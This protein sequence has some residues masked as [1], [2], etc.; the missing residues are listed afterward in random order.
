M[1]PIPNSR[2]RLL[3]TSRHVDAAHR[4]SLKIR[5]RDAFARSRSIS[6]SFVRCAAQSCVAVYRRAIGA[7]IASIDR[8]IA[9]AKYLAHRSRARVDPVVRRITIRDDTPATSMR[10]RQKRDL[11]VRG[12]DADDRCR[13]VARG[14]DWWMDVRGTGRGSSWAHPCGAWVWGAI[15]VYGGGDGA[16]DGRCMG[17]RWR[18]RRAR[19]RRGGDRWGAMYST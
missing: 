19:A 5:T 18:S 10:A 16:R 13:H 12:A 8:S 15:G 1:P 3:R 9:S 4:H 2:A 11:E 17:T 6:R 14:D 7:S